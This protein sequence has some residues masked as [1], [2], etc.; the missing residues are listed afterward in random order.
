MT[1]RPLNSSPIATWIAL[2]S[3]VATAA[4]MI[5]LPFTVKE[6]TDPFPMRILSVALVT[7]WLLA[8]YG[9]LVFLARWFAAHRDPSRGLL[10]ASIAM[11]ASA[12]FVAVSLFGARADGQGIM[13]LLALPV[14]QWMILGVSAAVASAAKRR[15]GRSH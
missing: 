12:A 11:A 8:P 15:P 5:G 2:A 1:D 4:V 7:G 9:G 13:L 6:A 14:F 10:V 3:A